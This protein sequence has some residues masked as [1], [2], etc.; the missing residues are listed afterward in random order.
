MRNRIAKSAL[1][2]GLLMVFS[3]SSFLQIFSPALGQGNASAAESY[4]YT[5]SLGFGPNDQDG[6]KKL[7][8]AIKDN[9]EGSDIL[10]S[11]FIG[12]KGGVFG[13][14]AMKLSYDSGKTGCAQSNKVS[15]GA[16]SGTTGDHFGGQDKTLYVYSGEYMCR[17]GKIIN[18]ASDQ[19]YYT[20]RYSVS[21]N[22]G[23]GNGVFNGDTLKNNTRLHWVGFGS[24]N[25][26]GA[27]FYPDTKPNTVRDSRDI[28][29]NRIPKGCLPPDV[30]SAVSN[31]P[32]KNSEEK[33]VGIINKFIPIL[34]RANN[35]VQETWRK[36]GINPGSGTASASGSGG[37]GSGDEVDIGCT[38]FTSALVWVIC[39][40]IDGFEAM[41]NELD[42]ILTS[43][44]S[45]GS[46]GNSD[47]PSNIF[48][49]K[50]SSDLKQCDAYHAAW[51]SFRNIAL[52][53]LL[54]IGLAVIISE[55]AGFEFFDAYTLKKMLPRIVVAALALTLS[56]QLM[57]FFVQLSNA[58]GFGIRYLIY[59]PFVNA[60]FDQAVIGGGGQATLIVLGGVM[61]SAM[62][63]FGVLSFIATAALAVLVAFL[64]IMIRE[65]VIIA[66]VII[67]PVA[68]ILYIM[69]NTEK[70]YKMW[71]EMFAKAL[72]M[73]PMIMAL[74]ASGRVFAATITTGAENDVFRQILGFAAY[75]APYFM[76][77]MTFKFS[78]M[79]MSAIGGAIDGQ[80]VGMR[81]GLSKYRRKKAAD[82]TQGAWQRAQTQQFFNENRKGRLGKYAGKANAALSNITSPGAA[83]KIYGGKALGKMGVDNSIGKSIF[84]S[85]GQTKFEHSQKLASKLNELGLNDR[86]LMSLEKL[87][88]YSPS[89]LRREV[90]RLSQ[91]SN[92]NDQIAATQLANTADFITSDL[93]K[94]AEM[95]RADV[96]AGAALA[97]ASQ[98]FMSSPE[99]ADV[100]NKLGG[101]EGG[102][103]LASAFA[104]TAQL[105]AQRAGVLDA[106]PGYGVQIDKDGQYFGVGAPDGAILS[107]NDRKRV[108]A[109]QVKRIGTTGQQ[110]LQGAKAP[111]VTRMAPGF[112][113]MLK[114][115]DFDANGNAA[116]TY[117]DANNNDQSVTVS[118]HEVERVA[119]MVG[120]ALA[121]YSGTSPATAAELQK[122]VDDAGLSGDT[123]SAFQRGRRDVDPSMQGGSPADQGGAPPPDD[124]K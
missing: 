72:M 32:D 47:N 66:L 16:C 50:N 113:E 42:N 71:W 20:V 35:S 111:S 96:M 70:Y 84:N 123:L 90:Q 46:P 121:D 52:G 97:R 104:T 99:I 11:T 6:L 5:F 49:D 106:K 36:A 51:A 55:M 74:I 29:I 44:L 17:N 43:Q 98:G 86:A 81:Q 54:I 19:A 34:E 58:L 82:R 60:G 15:S 68:I 64:T 78:G 110:D 102:G 114:I 75:F 3:F 56:W 23:G 37:S 13:D 14:K 124:Q 105:G 103:T 93:R 94:D 109:H 85:I 39:P 57:D 8:D 10:T 118:K 115:K 88:D 9:D 63:V 31:L 92:T 83:A 30:P 18:S 1:F 69:P 62:G 101:H 59:Q 79:A 65:L 119:G 25:T 45:V 61:L 33:N 21:V 122:I 95:G 38:Y 40:V 112:T 77:P 12:V 117:K 108:A 67:A 120:T 41:I 48:C 107:E 28:G 100:A 4:N 7:R 91:S 53:V 26:S 80:T 73:F 22:L 24:N 2:V 116:I 89:T 87:P 27:T 76:I